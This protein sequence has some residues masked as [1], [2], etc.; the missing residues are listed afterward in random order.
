MTGR[1]WLSRAKVQLFIICHFKRGLY[2]VPL[3][4]SCMAVLHIITSS[5]AAEHPTLLIDAADGT[6]LL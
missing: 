2:A 3:P 1:F 6:L 5:L 4:S